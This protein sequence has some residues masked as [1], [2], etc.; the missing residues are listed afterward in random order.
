MLNSNF[1][2]QVDKCYMG[3]QLSVIVSNICMTKAERKVVQPTKSK[4]YKAFANDIINK[5]YKD[6]SDNLFQ[7]LSSNHPKI[8]YA[9]EV[10][11]D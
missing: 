9:I 2:N 10:D 1:C 8:K 7:A 3:G 4:F 5:R 6:Q 11:P